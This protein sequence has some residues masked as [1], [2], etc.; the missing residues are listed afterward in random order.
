VLLTGPAIFP[1]STDRRHM[2]VPDRNLVLVVDDD[3]S[4]LRGV[5][6]L[7]RQ[8][9]YASLLFPSAAAF[10]EH[11]DFDEALCLLLDIDLGDGSGIEVRHRLK[12][13][14]TPPQATPTCPPPLWAFAHSRVGK[15]AMLPISG[16][17]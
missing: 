12:A 5:A 16:T 11:R 6:R 3:A 8:L 9:G 7:L 2:A 17:Q 14:S 4:M 1:L 15:F 10:A 13:R